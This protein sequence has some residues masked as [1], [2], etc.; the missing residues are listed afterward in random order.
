MLRLQ[1][2]P[3]TPMGSP[4][5]QPLPES[6]PAS[7]HPQMHPSGGGGGVTAA[8]VDPVGVLPTVPV[9]AMGGE[10]PQYTAMHPMLSPTTHLE[11]LAFVEQNR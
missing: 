11:T 2:L 9:S 10:Q 6:Q 5:P 4:P 7:P 3:G 8:L 1:L